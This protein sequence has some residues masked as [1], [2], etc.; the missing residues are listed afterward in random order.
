MVQV[1]DD[2]AAGRRHRCHT[3]RFAECDAGEIA[4]AGGLD[5]D[6]DADNEGLF[7]V[8]SHA[9]DDA[10]QFGWEARGA[11]DTGEAQS[12]TVEALCIGL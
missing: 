2:G 9:D 7:T 10:L 4:I 1:P 3:H 8:E 6:G 12:F 5:W 11:N